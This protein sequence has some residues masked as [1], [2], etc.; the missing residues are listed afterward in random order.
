MQV[1]DPRASIGDFVWEDLDRDGT[2]DVDE[3]GVDGI[4]VQ[5]FD[6]TGT[7]VGLTRTEADG[8]YLISDLVPGAYWLR[9]Q[10]TSAFEFTEGRAGVDQTIDSDVF[11][12]GGIVGPYV[13]SPGQSLASVDAGL[14]RPLRSAIGLAQQLVGEPTATDDG[15]LVQVRF[16]FDNLGETLLTEVAIDTGLETVF[17]DATVVTPQFRVDS[18]CVIED[19]AIGSTLD[20]GQSC[21]ST[22]QIEVADVELDLLYFNSARAAAKAPN[23]SEVN[24]LSDDGPVSDTNGDGSADE[25][26]E[27]DPTPI[28]IAGRVGDVNCDSLTD[29]VDALMIAQHST[30]VR[31]A[32]TACADVGPSTLVASYGDVDG[33][34]VTDIVDALFIAQCDVG[35]SNTFCPAP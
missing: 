22:W 6:S 8:S 10:S 31:E 1:E 11:S 18:D 17:A 28:V 7:V 25:A 23:G 34:G 3:P 16:V 19:G 4:I 29:V 27:N 5:A 12:A 20:V 24:D 13:V 26:G 30:T 35:L 15:Y 14:V 9:F 33:S 21:F 2:Q 32:V